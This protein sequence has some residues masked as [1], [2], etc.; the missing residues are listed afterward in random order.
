MCT[1]FL[2]TFSEKNSEI[3][4]LSLLIYSVAK[5]FEMRRLPELA[6]WITQFF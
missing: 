5:I 6:A 3:E 1:T 2:F 4:N